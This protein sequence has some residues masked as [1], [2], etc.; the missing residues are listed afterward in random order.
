MCSSSAPSEGR[1]CEGKKEKTM[2]HEPEPRS[3]VS[4]CR[5]RCGFCFGSFRG[6]LVS[7][8]LG[9]C[10]RGRGEKTKGRRR[11]A[12]ASCL[13]LAA[14]GGVW[15]GPRTAAPRRP[16]H[17]SFPAPARPTT[18]SS[19]L[20][21]RDCPDCP[22]PHTPLRRRPAG[23]TCT[24]PT[25]AAPPPLDSVALGLP[26]AECTHTKYNTRSVLFPVSRSRAEPSPNKRPN[27]LCPH[28]GKRK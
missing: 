15:T 21:S 14:P 10:A 4:C 28:N 2:R 27:L 8:I 24:Q 26:T 19:C 11:G 20:L 13:W 3:L 12:H 6:Q 16:I 25:E 23:L 1:V 22:L 5:A 9:L 7:L 17:S 18:C